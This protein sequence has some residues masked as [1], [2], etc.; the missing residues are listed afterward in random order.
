MSG[1]I[2]II[3]S[4]PVWQNINRLGISIKLSY[5]TE[6]ELEETIHNTIAPYKNQI[7]I[8]WDETDYKNAAT[9]L[10][11]LSE[12]EA[13]NIISSIILILLKK[14]SFLSASR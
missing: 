12:M 13:K 14:V 10:Q 7:Q 3:T 2:V 6:Q 9:Y 11:G 1:T 8:E 4:E 5:P